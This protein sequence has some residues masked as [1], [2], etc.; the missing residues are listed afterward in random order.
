MR[1]QIL[2]ELPNEKLPKNFV[3]LVTF[4]VEANK[5]IFLQVQAKKGT[6]TSARLWEGT[7]L[8]SEINSLTVGCLRTDTQLDPEHKFPDCGLPLKRHTVR[9]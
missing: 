7:R 4:L 3:P 8:E 2:I 9:S 5:A 6:I 1:Q